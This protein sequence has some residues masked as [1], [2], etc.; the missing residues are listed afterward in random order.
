MTSEN[1]GPTMREILETHNVEELERI[2]GEIIKNAGLARA[3]VS[4]G[5][6]ESWD[7]EALRRYAGTVVFHAEA[8]EPGLTKL[9]GPQKAN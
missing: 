6:P 2:L 3:I 7:K 1:E 5:A 4:S 8:I 9:I